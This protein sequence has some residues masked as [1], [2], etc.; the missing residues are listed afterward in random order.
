MTISNRFYLRDQSGT[1]E[2]FPLPV[3]PRIALRPGLII[4]LQDNNTKLCVTNITGTNS[5]KE[6]TEVED[7]KFPVSVLQCYCETCERN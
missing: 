1:H 2:D 7:F 4:P 3:G 6:H 5:S